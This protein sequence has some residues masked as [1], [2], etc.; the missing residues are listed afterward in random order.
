MLLARRSVLET[1]GFNSRSFEIS[2]TFGLSC[3]MSKHRALGTGYPEV[4]FPLG[5]ARRYGGGWFGVPL[6][7]SLKT[8]RRDAAGLPACASM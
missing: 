7:A 6:P 5:T 4:P 3:R 1:L 8:E 2:A